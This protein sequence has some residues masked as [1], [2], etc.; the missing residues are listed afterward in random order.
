MPAEIERGQRFHQQRRPELRRRCACV[1]IG[2]A[3]IG[4]RP[5]GLSTGSGRDR[6]KAGW[7]LTGTN[8]VYR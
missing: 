1:V 2:H 3:L 8:A 4:A 5:G 7:L 6:E